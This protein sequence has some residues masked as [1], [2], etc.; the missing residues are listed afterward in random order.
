MKILHKNKPNPKYKRG[1]TGKFRHFTR[2]AAIDTLPLLQARAPEI[3][4][5]VYRCPYCEQ[6]HVG[7]KETR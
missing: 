7:S 2:E 5:H 1:C 3:S 6:F 4:F